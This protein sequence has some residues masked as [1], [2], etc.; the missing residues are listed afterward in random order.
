MIS[1]NSGNNIMFEQSLGI[2]KRI[3]LKIFFYKNTKI[4]NLRRSN[5]ILI[6]NFVVMSNQ[7]YI[8]LKQIISQNLLRF[9]NC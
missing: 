6:L 4:R 2:K 8:H 5:K 3:I 7:V 9:D 1:K